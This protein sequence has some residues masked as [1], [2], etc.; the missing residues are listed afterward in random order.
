MNDSFAPSGIDMPSP[1]LSA[2]LKE[3]GAYLAAPAAGR[4]TEEQ[5]A[6]ALGIA[7]RLVRDM[8]GVLDHAI[9]ASALWRDWTAQGLPAARRLAEPCFARAEE[10][11]WRK[12]SSPQAGAPPDPAAENRV[13]E[14]SGPPV[15]DAP[16]TA[17]EQA[18]LALRIAD[19]R[20]RDALG[21]PCIA[22]ADLDEGLFRSLLLDMAAWQ[23]ARIA[24]DRGQGAKLGDAVNE[25]LAGRADARGIDAAA[26]R[27]HGAVAA[28]GAV[29]ETAR[30][31]IAR[32]DWPALIALA[33][34]AHGQRYETT[35]LMLLTAE[36]A[37]LPSRLAPLRL[38]RAAIAPL[39]A[40]LARLADRA[41]AGGAD[42]IG[43]EPA[44]AGK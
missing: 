23:L 30:A 4:L 29:P 12:Q 6:L 7:R 9:D 36:P 35:A 2:R 38:D 28:D 26:L 39:E 34:G 11:R 14:A 25:L 21:N 42:E 22:P 15:G 10:Y 37:A 27:Y 13:E 5:R 43:P 41:I 18:Y 31:A 1:T 20:R 32:H 40:S 8:A 3:L 33:A 17:A 16:L 19:G 44:G 24:G